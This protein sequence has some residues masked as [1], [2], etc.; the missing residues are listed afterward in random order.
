MDRNLKVILSSIIVL[1]ICAYF[2]DSILLNII[3]AAIVG[4][5]SFFGAVTV[6]L[7]SAPLCV[8]A[9]SV[10][11]IVFLTGLGFSTKS[12]ILIILIPVIISIIA[13]I[14]FVKALIKRKGKIDESS[15]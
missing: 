13:G 6:C 9:I 5:L 10:G 7:V 3:V 4:I 8:P 14:L 2:I 15:S 11:A 1:A 12:A